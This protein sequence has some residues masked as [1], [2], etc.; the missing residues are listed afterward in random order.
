MNTIPD[1]PSMDSET[2]AAPAAGIARSGHLDGVDDE[3]RIRF[4]P[5]GAAVSEPAAIATAIADAVL[6]R[7]AR[8][9]ARALAVRTADPNPGWIVVGLIRE[10]LA[11]DALNAKG[12]LQ[13][14]YEGESL[15]LAADRDLSLSC[16]KASLTLRFDG[17]IELHG[18]NI[19]SAAR[20]QQRIKGA[21]VAIN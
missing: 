9:K 10:R 11:H 7:A 18:T 1:I 5:E 19:L 16:G 17:R 4:L 12:A 14:C 15:R 8:N 20:G 6:L 3:G 2:I 21:T 13:V